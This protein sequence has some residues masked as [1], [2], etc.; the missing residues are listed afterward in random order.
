MAAADQLLLDDEDPG[1]GILS[2]DDDQSEANVATKATT[3]FLNNKLDHVVPAAGQNR[4][5]FA[6]EAG[7]GAPLA[8]L[9]LGTENREDHFDHF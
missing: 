3:P 5:S 1:G 7:R 8:E 2:D 9:A 4:F 6:P